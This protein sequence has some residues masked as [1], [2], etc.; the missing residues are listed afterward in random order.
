[1]PCSLAKKLRIDETTPNRS[2]GV[3]GTSS[4]LSTH[5]SKG[6]RKLATKRT[7]LESQFRIEHF[8]HHVFQLGR[9]E[10][11]KQRLLRS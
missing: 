2:M 5:F 9:E 7:I 10:V 11:K 4:L 1:M 8:C 6:N 3:D